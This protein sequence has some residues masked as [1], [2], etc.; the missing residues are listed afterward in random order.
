LIAS[1]YRDDATER[2]QRIHQIGRI[3]PVEEKWI[4]LDGTAIDVEVTAESFWRDNKPAVL[5]IARDVTEYKRIEALLHESESRHRRL[6]ELY[7]DLIGVES[8]R[9]A[10]LQN[11]LRRAREVD[12]LKSHLLSIV[13]HELRTPLTAI[14]GQTSTLLDYESEMSREEQ[15]EALRA[16]DKEA[17]RLDELIGNVLDMS[18]LE[19]GTLSLEWVA[20]DICPIL[21]EEIDSIAASAP[22]HTVLATIPDLPLAQADPRRLRQVIR[23]LLENAVKFSRPGTRIHVEAEANPT[24]ILI[25]VHDEGIGIAEEHLPHIFDRF[26]RAERGSIRGSGMGLGLAICRGLIEAMGGRLQVASHVGQ[27]STFSFSL[28]LAQ[29]GIRHAQE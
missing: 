18:R 5:L 23:N 3:G 11:A 2:L 17:A 4:R 20:V 13:S 14:R 27:G 22:D 25:H 10:E 12:E 15:I 8:A 26:Y 16:I 28:P 7:L 1:D 6:T 9:T 24:A 29:G 21:R 19:S